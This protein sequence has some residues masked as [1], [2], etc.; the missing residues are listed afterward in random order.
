LTFIQENI[1]DNSKVIVELCDVASPS[2]L[3]H[4]LAATQPDILLLSCHGGYDRRRRLAGVYIGDELRIGP[5]L[6]PMPPVVILSACNVAPRGT[7]AV[8]IAELLAR[9][10]ALTVLATQTPVDVR[11]NAHIMMRFLLY[12]AESLA[13][14][15]PHVTLAEAWHRAATSNAV[16]DILSG[17]DALNRWAHERRAGISPIEEF[18]Q[19]RSVG[20]LR[21]GHIYEDSEALLLELAIEHGLEDEMRTHIE[22]KAYVPETLF[23]FLLGWPDRIRLN[24]PIIEKYR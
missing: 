14:R 22:K 16:L 12:L 1:G 18:M 17:D 15:E 3:Q 19:S 2:D 13:G 9:E 11:R 6:G 4:T 20:R 7:G 5:E 24:D 23:Y 8:N 10:G 21:L